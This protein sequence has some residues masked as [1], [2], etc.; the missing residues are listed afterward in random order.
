MHLLLLKPH[1]WVQ[2]ELRQQQ[3]PPHVQEEQQM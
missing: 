1:A 2:L 3:Q